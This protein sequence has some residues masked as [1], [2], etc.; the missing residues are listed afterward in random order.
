MRDNGN[1]E[2]GCVCTK[3]LISIHCLLLVLFVLVQEATL[4]T[5]RPETNVSQVVCF[6]H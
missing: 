4:T 6:R 2:F 3:R 5:T 1:G